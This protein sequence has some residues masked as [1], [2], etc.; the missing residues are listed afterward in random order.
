MRER[1]HGDLGADV[2]HE[3]SR[4]TDRPG[5]LRAALQLTLLG[6]STAV[7]LTTASPTAWWLAFVAQAVA[8]FAMFGLLHESIHGTAFASPFANAAGSWIGAVWQ[9]SPP[10][11]MR[12]FHFEHHRHTHE[13]ARDPELAGMAWMARWPRGLAWLVTVSGSPIL[14]AR[15]G[16]TLVAATGITPLLRKAL[17]YAAAER[18]GAI[19]RDARILLLVH[20]TLVALAVTVAPR[21]GALWLAALPAHAILSIYLTCE[22]RGLPESGDVLHR[23][24]SLRAGPTLR[25][26][27]WNMPFHAEHHAYPSVPFHALPR[28]HTLLAAHL[29]NV[30]RSVLDLHRG[31]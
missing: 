3:L 6:A 21:L 18:F 2:L 24:R 23:T 15:V 9:F 10:A 27:L 7:L 13:L 17:P 26:L 11:W 31:R 25:F 12:A 14:I 30:G 5:L 29:P 16:I 19:T 1:F 28:L 4:R 20:A 22:H 8:Q